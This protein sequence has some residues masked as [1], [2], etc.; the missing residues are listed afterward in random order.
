MKTYRLLNPDEIVQSGDEFYRTSDAT[1]NTVSFGTGARVESPSFASNLFRRQLQVDEWIDYSKQKPTKEDGYGPYGQVEYI[2]RG[3]AY[4]ASYCAQWA[5]SP[6]FWRRITPPTPVV[7]P[8][9]IKD[10]VVVFNPDKSVTVGCTT[11][12]AKTMEKIIERYTK[13]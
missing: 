8:I 7:P 1:W 13:A 9:K 10:H 12:D 2:R 6:E 3:A 5:E 11:V 4:E